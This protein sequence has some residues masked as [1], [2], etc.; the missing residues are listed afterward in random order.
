M[1]SALDAERAANAAKNERLDLYAAEISALK[2]SVATLESQKRDLASVV[3]TK[4]DDIESLKRENSRLKTEINESRSENR[5]LNTQISSMQSAE[6]KLRLERA[7]RDQEWEQ[8]RRDVVW[9]NDELKR[10]DADFKAY[11][12][13]KGD[14]IQKLQIDLD[15]VIQEK[16]TYEIQAKG[17]QEKC[18]K[19]EKRI[20]EL[21]EKVKECENLIINNEQ[22]FTNEMKAQRNINA[23]CETQTRHLE[24]QVKDLQRLIADLEA[25]MEE[26]NEKRDEAVVLLRRTEEE[27]NSAME[28]KDLKIEELQAQLKNI[29]DGALSNLK[30][31]DLLSPAAKA[32][33]A[34]QKS[35]KSFT[36]VAPIF[37]QM[38]ADKISAEREVIRLTDEL[39][40]SLRMVS[41][42]DLI[43]RNC[44]D[45]IVNLETQNKQ[46][47]HESHDLARQ[48]QHL[49]VEIETFRAG[50]GGLKSLA[51]SLAL[52]D[53]V[54]A[55]SPSGRVISERLVIFNNI[56]E[57]QT[58]NQQL[59]V[60][61]RSVSDRLE[62]LKAEQVAAIDEKVAK[63]MEEAMMALEDLK[64]QLRVGNIKCQSY[65]RERDQWKA[66]AE[67]RGYAGGGSGGVKSASPAK[68]NGVS[69]SRS[70]DYHAMFMNVQRDFDIFRKEIGSDTERLKTANE[71]LR[72]ENN[73]LIVQVARLNSTVENINERYKALSDNSESQLK[74]N[75]QL[76]E[77]VSSL[78]N[79][80]ST[81]DT[82]AQG[83]T[84][85]V[86]EIRS[87][88]DAANTELRQLRGEKEVLKA[89][90]ARM[91]A[92]NKGMLEQRNMANE[93]L[94]SLQ[95]MFD[96]LD[97]QGREN[98]ARAEAKVAR[99]EKE[100]ELLRLQL[101]SAID[102]SRSLSAQR[103]LEGKEAQKKIDR[104]TGELSTATKDTEVARAEERGLRVRVEDLLSR[105][106]A[107]E[108]KLKVYE[109]S[110]TSLTSELT[111]GQRIK[112]LKAE[113]A[114]TRESLR[115]EKD[116]V[117]QYKAISAASEEK[118][119]ESLASYD[120]YKQEMES[121]KAELE[122]LLDAAERKRGDLEER[123]S[124][125]AADITELQDKA[126][127]DRSEFEFEKGRFV[128]E[129]AMLRK[130]EETTYERRLQEARA[131][132]DRVIVAEGERIKA[133]QKMEQD[134]STLRG[135]SNA[136]KQQ[137]QTAER[138][139]QTSQDSWNAVQSKLQEQ[140]DALQ[141]TNDDLNVQNRLLH[142]Q[143]QSMTQRIQSIQNTKF[144]AGDA[145]AA[146]G[147][148]AVKAASI[149]E[150]EKAEIINY[151]RREKQILEEKLA[152]FEM[153]SVRL[154]Q[155][156]EHLQRSLDE[157]RAALDNVRLPSY[158]MRINLATSVNV[159]E[160]NLGL[161]AEIDAVRNSMRSLEEDNN[162]W[163]A[164]TQQI[165]SK[166]ER[167]DPVEHQRLKDQVAELIV[168]V[169]QFTAEIGTK[170]ARIAELEGQVEELRAR[171]VAAEQSL[172]QL[173]NNS[174]SEVQ[175]LLS[176]KANGEQ[177]KLGE[178]LENEK[179]RRKQVVERANEITTRLK[180]EIK[181]L[182]NE[183]EI[184]ATEMDALKTKLSEAA[185][186]KQSMDTLKLK[187]SDYE[188]K[189]AQLESA[190]VQRQAAP[191]RIE[192]SAKTSLDDTAA[193][194]LV[195][196]KLPPV[197]PA[198]ITAT[199]S[200]GTEATATLAP[201]THLN[202]F[203]SPSTKR[204]RDDAVA[205]AERVARSPA[206]KPTDPD[207]TML[208]D[209]EPAAKRARTDGAG[210]TPSGPVLSAPQQNP[211]RDSLDEMETDANVP[212]GAV[213]IPKADAEK[214]TEQPPP[215]PEPSE[216]LLE[217]TM[218]AI[219]EGDRVAD[220]G[221]GV[222]VDST[223]SAAEVLPDPM[224]STTLMENG[225][226]APT[227]TEQLAEPLPEA[228]EEELEDTGGLLKQ[229]AMEDGEMT[230]Q[231]S[232][233][234]TFA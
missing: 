38:K 191:N 223:I 192:P 21:V 169:E 22:L 175:I 166:Y 11:R 1:A 78:L 114:Q 158:D 111:D 28:A 138:N 189:I 178:L 46:L 217:D 226:Q 220:D 174:Q 207:A 61:L 132:Y 196:S 147:D 55:E 155:Q 83:L 9:L 41:D 103:D 74:E 63:E 67:N 75:S 112:E 109:G 133:L 206:L 70:E 208:I 76:R 82:K 170:N 199:V 193:S 66:I 179:V 107:A 26:L 228:F 64:E 215:A 209:E 35:G 182:K 148:E 187:V 139:L 124:R 214:A 99:V 204:P 79:A 16:N 10:K 101:N 91:I 113:L 115:L 205:N 68:R 14:A 3:D 123:L 40:K 184:F 77:R 172:T 27:Y 43:S 180:G 13:E 73:N 106:A 162:R 127:K 216:E 34:F 20:F 52:Q 137:A 51:S 84:N 86:L 24:E 80:I 85:K 105:V 102:E 118:L 48:V 59:R 29:N 122:A 92:E 200:Q 150:K 186:D 210:E 156:A 49:L 72:T 15:A 96:E 198:L 120:E 31:L 121:K 8:Q 142:D 224:E 152:M 32:A 89:A 183:K 159:V 194:T 185:A 36:E 197:A 125:T 129:I 135:E 81:Q 6:V 69:E 2:S 134:L 233:Y 53:D 90:E 153:E 213:P 108:E 93:H 98:A 164:R 44:R 171:A 181:S 232:A 176:M 39:T 5:A 190:V 30:T 146:T 117:E 45:Q 227:E 19:Q 221:A 95:R 65:I 222:T 50:P 104:L 177:A 165:L 201:K 225:D 18:D 23:L 202:T 218:D 151:L 154:K 140:I 145:G 25:G 141:K 56:A 234:L 131:D 58:Q 143:F 116:R 161:K 229:D 7:S 37:N 42:L 4:F 17:L 33:A 71:T 230:E 110:S 126:D 88:L 173:R 211:Q 144:T 119:V 195:L 60:S 168:K 188:R 167:I 212:S 97:R 62:S 157:C 136:L 149:L 219:E 128:D 160:E 163:K 130:S 231:A 47:A 12:T 94:T 203:S 57:L 100:M 87:A 54:A